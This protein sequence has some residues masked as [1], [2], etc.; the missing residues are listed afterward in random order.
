MTQANEEYR[1]FGANL[2]ERILPHRR[3][4]LFVDRVKRFRLGAERSIEASLEISINDP[5]FDGHFPNWSLWPGV[6]V[7]EG[8]GQTAQLLATLDMVRQAGAQ[9]H[10]EGLGFRALDALDALYSLRPG[11]APSDEG[12]ALLKEISSSPVVGLA[13]RID[14]RFLEPVFPGSRLDYR[15]EW[16]LEHNGVM[17]FNVEASVG[18][19]PVARGELGA[20]VNTRIPR[21]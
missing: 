7:V 14:M 4:F 21:S 18:G 10:D 9:R 2:V 12:L 19:R 5:V 20:S 11:A 17:G 8:L 3:P 16:T 13:T 15:V 1:G 6:Y